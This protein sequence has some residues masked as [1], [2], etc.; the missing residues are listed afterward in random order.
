MFLAFRSRWTVKAS[1]SKSVLNNYKVFQ[2][3]RVGAKDIAPDLEIC[4]HMAGVEFKMNMFPYL[5]GIRLG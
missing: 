5:C 3:V 4:I 2:A 1:S